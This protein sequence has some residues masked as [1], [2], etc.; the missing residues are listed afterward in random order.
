MADE[1]DDL[2]QPQFIPAPTID[3]PKGNYATPGFVIEAHAFLPGAPITKWWIQIR[4]GNELRHRAEPPFTSYPTYSSMKYEVPENILAPG[5]VFFVRVQYEVSWIPESEWAYTQDMTMVS[6]PPPP[7]FTGPTALT[8]RRPTF[9]GT[10]YEGATVYVTQQNQASPILASALVINGAWQATLRSDIPDLPAGPYEVS[11]QQIFKDMASRWV[12]PPFVIQVKP[13]DPV[14]VGPEEEDVIDHGGIFYGNHGYSGPGSRVTLQQEGGHEWAHAFPNANDGSW[15]STPLP[16]DIGYG[17]KTLYVRVDVENYHSEYVVRNFT[18]RPPVPYIT[19]PTAAT[20]PQPTITGTG[21]ERATVNVVQQNHATPVLATAMVVNGTWEAPLSSGSV[22]LP[23]GRF[24]LSAQQIID[25]T[26]SKWLNPPFELKVKPPKPAIS[27]VSNPVSPKQV[28]TITG[29]YSATVTL[30]LFTEEGIK[31][32]GAFNTTA[33]GSTFTP[34]A[35]WPAGNTRVKVVQAVDSVPSDSSDLRLITRIPAKPVITPPPNPASA[36][37]ILNITDV[38]SSTATL[39]MIT[40]A[41][42]TVEGE[43]LGS[44]DSRRFIPATEWTPGTTEVQVVQTVNGLDSDPSDPCSITVKPTILWI[45]PPPR[46]PAPRQSLIIT[47]VFSGAVTLKIINAAGAIVPGTFNTTGTSSTFTPTAEWPLGVNQVQ[48]V[49][50]VNGLD[51]DPSD[52]RSFTVT[53]E[54]PAIT[55]PPNPATPTQV[56]TITGVYSGT[57]TTTLEILT[58]AGTKI[59]GTFSGTGTNRTFTPTTNWPTGTTVVKA[60]QTVDG[61]VSAPSGLRRINIKPAKPVI[62]QPP[63]PS[64]P[65]QTLTITGVFSGNVT[66]EVFTESGAKVA[67][68]ISGTG[69]TRTFTPTADWPTGTTQVKAVQTVGGV[70]SDPSDL[71][72]I[73]VKP[74]KLVIQPPP[75]PSPPKQPLTITE[76]YSRAGTVTVELFTEAGVNVAGNF[77]GTGTTRTFTPTASWPKGTTQVKAVQ[78]VG[79]VPSDPSDLCSIIVELVTPPTLVITPPR[80]PSPPRQQLSIFE[81]LHNASSV[82]IFTEAGVNVAGNFTGTGNP[83]TF[84]P[85]ADW[86]TGTTLVKAVQTVGGVSSDPSDL[87]PITVRPNTPTLAQPPNPSAVRQTLS[88]TGVYSG[89]VT[90]KIFTETGNEVTGN[91]TGTGASRTFTPSKDWPPGDTRV[92]AEQTVG[93]VRSEFSNLGLIAIKPAKLVIAQPPNPAI[94]RQTLTITGIVSGTVEISDETG[95]RFYGDIRDTG[96]SHTF[97]P[98]NDWPMGTTQIKAEQFVNGMRSDPSDLCSITVKPPK[99]VIQP[100]PT[101]S[102]PKQPLTITEVYSRAGTVTVELFTEAGAEV[103]GNFTSTGDGRIFR[104]TNDWPPGINKVKAEQTVGGVRSDPSDLRSITV[105]PA[106]LVIQQPPTPATPKQPLTITE[107]YSR[108][109]T[110]TV[111]LFTEA[112]AE[113]AGNFTGTGDSRIFTPTNDWPPGINKVKAEQTVGGV[114]S[115]ASDLCVFTVQ[116]PVGPDAPRFD[117]PLPN[118]QTPSRPQ[119]KVVGLPGALMSVRFF[120]G[121]VWHE[122][123]A[124]AEGRLMFSPAAPLGPGHISLQVKQKSDGA[125]SPWSEPHDFMALPRPS[126]PAVNRPTESSAVSRK[127]QISGSGTTGGEIHLRDVDAPDNLLGT[128]AGRRSWRWA[129]TENWALGFHRVEVQQEDRGDDSEWS[130]PRRFE[131]VDTLYEFVA[132]DTVLAQPAVSCDASV[133][134]QVQ[135]VSTN[136]RQGVQGVSVEWYVDDEPIA[137]ETTLTDQEGRTRFVYSPESPDEHWVEAAITHENQGVATTQLFVVKAV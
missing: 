59:A 54:A 111:E 20:T 100:P 63:T 45:D 74:A 9:N 57:G 83:R 120:E 80:P 78:T 108:A 56:L 36:K 42:D 66:V 104:P 13:S 37:E 85:T 39:K 58:E 29:V 93:G 79:G 31:I 101:P 91:V 6:Y 47:R 61:V 96:A 76:V 10:G 3:A 11:A 4:V 53:L 73:A 127:P 43:F 114:R 116:E 125:E 30:E 130:T 88:I 60:V 129:A 34:T 81:V 8:N 52:P 106:K 121:E 62:T 46:P 115:D 126:T 113:V 137:R 124:D 131:V 86:P 32:A 67:G 90:V 95:T 7:V 70:P 136:N 15:S 2:Q 98:I 117:L 48:A 28:L 77:T 112:G 51:S 14:I 18:I 22:S 110:V 5:E 128:T 72:S 33:T 103:A 64:A 89:T 122:Q 44:S 24:W 38:H 94:P 87:I 133:V 27:A 40:V 69:T 132:A 109:G 26:E 41:G 102:Y 105:K 107:V 75:T 71:C 50:T 25:A 65:K 97:V 99:L 1:K 21:S 134:L 118:S 68:A 17:R 35:D 12:N 82:E 135:V 23:A 123:L 92:K 119:I 19:G 49:Q 16:L 84:T 55:S